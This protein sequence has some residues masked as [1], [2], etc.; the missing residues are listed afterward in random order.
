MVRTAA[1]PVTMVISF[2]TIIMANYPSTTITKRLCTHI[3]YTPHS[4]TGMNWQCA[5]NFL[6]DNVKFCYCKYILY[7]EK[8]TSL[9]FELFLL[10]NIKFCCI[11]RSLNMTEYFITSNDTYFQQNIF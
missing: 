1:H 11:I 7:K 5:R 9:I 2:N 3:H 10:K 4:A 8:K 6:K